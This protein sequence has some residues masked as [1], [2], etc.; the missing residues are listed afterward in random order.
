[1]T[2]SAK[3][4]ESDEINHWKKSQTKLIIGKLDEKEKNAFNLR[5]IPYLVMSHE[6]MMNMI[7]LDLSYRIT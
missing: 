4:K 3:K 7:C 5:L 2:I 1:M 6:I